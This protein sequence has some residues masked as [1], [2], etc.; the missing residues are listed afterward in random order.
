MTMLKVGVIADDFTGAS[1]A[2]SFLAKGGLKTLMSD[3]PIFDVPEDV[4]AVVIALKSRSVEVAQAIKMVADAYASLS[5]VGFEKLYFKYCST[6]DST[7]KGNIGPVLDYLCEKL[8][9]KYALVCPSLPVN[10]R[11][12]KDG[13]LYVN[14]VPLDESP[15]KDHPLNPMWDSY[16]PSLLKPQSKYPC[17]VLKTQDLSDGSYK[18]KIEK[19]PDEHFYIVPDYEDD[20]DGKLIAD[21]F[22]DAHMLSGGS[23]L[24]EYLGHDRQVAKA[25]T[26]RV[27]KKSLIL[28]GSCSKMTKKQVHRY[29]DKGHKAYKID[30]FSLLERDLAQDLFKKIEQ[31]DDTVIVY[32][33]GIDK[34]MSEL[35]EKES[36]QEASKAMEDLLAKLAVLAYHK[37]YDDIIVAGGETSGAIM[38]ALDLKAFI[39]GDSID[40]G[41]PELFPLNA[42]MRLILKSGNFGSE[43]FFIKAIGEKD[44]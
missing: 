4:E 8:D 41:V 23:G 5:K 37:G 11:T 26:K 40:P 13:H 44:E 22:K 16:I 2:A 7:K 15:M 27:F 38:R 33:D 30:A 18:E 3:G 14:G 9:V 25:N 36:F 12:L 39:L 21:T 20:K 19:M 43:D 32:S 24:L 42:D 35:R 31:E 1:D 34:D 10:G 29:I 17:L 6:F 28:C